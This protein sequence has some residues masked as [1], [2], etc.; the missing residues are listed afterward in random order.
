MWTDRKACTIVKITDSQIHVQ[1]D[2]STRRDNNG[3]S[4]DQHYDYMP[5][6]K[7][8]IIIFRKTKQ[9]YKSNQSSFLS[10]GSR[11]SYHDYSF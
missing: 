6:T 4:E 10:V 5:N 3:M 1:E 2:I 7:S 8:P 9:G 11:N